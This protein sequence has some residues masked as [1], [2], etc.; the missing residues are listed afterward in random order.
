MDRYIIESPSVLQHY[1]KTLATVNSIR[2]IYMQFQGYGI[3]DL[4]FRLLIILLRSFYV[5]SR[6]ALVV[7]NLQ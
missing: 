3:F 5:S 6:L 4:V 7:S 2:K 1:R